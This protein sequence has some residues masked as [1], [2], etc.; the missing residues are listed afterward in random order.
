VA[1]LACLVV[2]VLAGAVGLATLHYA[3]QV[4]SSVRRVDPFAQITG[5]R[6]AD[7]APGA[8]NILLL[9]SDSR[10]PAVTTGSRSDTIILMHLPA[11]HRHA[12]FISIPRDT[13]VYIPRSPTNPDVGDTHDKINAAFAWGGATLAVQTVEAFTGVRI[14]HVVLLDFA[15]F[16]RV[17]DALGGVTMT[18]DQTITSIFPPYRVFTAG[19]HHF[20][21]AEALD[22]VRQREQFPDS[23]ITREKHQQEFLKAVMDTAAST[24]TLTDPL[25]LNAFVHALSA[26]IVADRGLS[27]PDFVVGFHSLRS[28]DLTFLTSPY[29][30]FDTI[31]DQSV[32]I[33]DPQRTQPLYRAVAHDQ[34]GS[35]LASQRTASPSP[36]S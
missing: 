6:P 16:A 11:D 25:R 13:Y 22:Y 33:S 36:T 35:Y 18:V 20:S 31:D 28:A 21:G 27:I 14:H 15:G 26:A 3:H 23:D 29:S 9:G 32:V 17:T 12:Y 30:G 4:D 5:G 1:L 8:V 7:V 34:L 19:Q 2:L 10:D 24:G